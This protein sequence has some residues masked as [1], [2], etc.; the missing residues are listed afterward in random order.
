MSFS[1]PEEVR[2][3]YDAGMIDLHSMISVRMGKERF[4]STVG[5]ILLWE[6]IPQDN[7]MQLRY[8]TVAEEVDA[9]AALDALNGNGVRS[10]CGRTLRR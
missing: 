2:V 8:L 4:D 10:G 9:L 3:A 6:V 1:S 5:R 7:L